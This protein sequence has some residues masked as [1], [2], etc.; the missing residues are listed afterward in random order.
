M[1][2]GQHEVLHATVPFSPAS[3]EIETAEKYGGKQ[4]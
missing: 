3:N 4:R 1:H 2:A